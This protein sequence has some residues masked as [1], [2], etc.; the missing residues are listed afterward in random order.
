M[1]EVSS[2]LEFELRWLAARWSLVQVEPLSLVVLW[3]V[4]WLVLLR[5]CKHAYK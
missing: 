4:V 5:M 3:L 1:L 2:S